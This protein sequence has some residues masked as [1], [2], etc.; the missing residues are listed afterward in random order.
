MS[1]R[2]GIMKINAGLVYLSVFYLSC[3]PDGI[4]LE[5]F[6]YIH[7]FHQ[8]VQ[9]DNIEEVKSFLSVKT[10]DS[11]EFKGQRR[12]Y[13]IEDKICSDVNFKSVRKGG[14]NRTALFYVRSLK[15]AE[16][17]V[18]EGAVVKVQD[19]RGYTPLH[20]AYNPYVANFFISQGSDI[21]AQAK[22]DDEEKGETPLYTAI[23]SERYDVAELLFKKGANPHAENNLGETP[24]SEAK[25]KSSWHTFRLNRLIKDFESYTPPQKNPSAVSP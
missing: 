16:Y 2:K 15:M 17:L 4:M 12:D 24:L 5:D 9:E 20:F 13:L 18:S 25:S 14:A 11:E 1:R 22:D 6:H 7:D 10:C 3:V 19:K 8:A 23:R 21:E